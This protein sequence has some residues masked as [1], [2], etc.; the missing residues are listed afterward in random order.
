MN[1]FKQ[2][3]HEVI[4][5]LSV[6]VLLTF[7]GMVQ[8][9]IFLTPAAAIPAKA[10]T[11]Q[12][13]DV[14]K[15]PWGALDMKKMIRLGILQGYSENNAFYAKPEKLITRAEFASL[16]ARSIGLPD[17]A[18]EL[19]FTDSKDIPEWARGAVGALYDKGIVKGD[20][21]LFGK[22]YFKPQDNVKRSE[23]VAMVT[24]AIDAKPEETLS[25]P[26][27]D[28]H[29]KDWFYQ[30][31]LTAN[32]LGIVSGRTAKTFVPNGTAKRVEVMAILSRFL[33]KDSAK[34]DSDSSI[35]SAVR[36]Y[37]DKL[38]K[39]LGSGKNEKGML[40][41]VTGEMELGLQNGGAGLWEGVPWKG[42]AVRMNHPWGSTEVTAK[43]NRLATV[44]YRIQV[45]MISSDKDT[46]GLK[47]LVGEKVYLVK[48]GDNWKVYATDITSSD[49]EER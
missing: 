11:N 14:D 44:N 25:N 20:S 39:L 2:Y 19:P 5:V 10:F 12:F 7:G 4:V 45:E 24:R 49:T 40:P 34:T 28:V 30:N 33:E 8:R 38:E 29:E 36:S 1:Y 16:L 23:I 35:T 43:S 48:D 47:T 46:P 21:G 6:M 17:K 22:T 31:V 41:L 42:T 32:K 18:N 27:S 15:H 13:V 9:N 37:H 3:T 26:F